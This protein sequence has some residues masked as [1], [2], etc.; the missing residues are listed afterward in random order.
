MILKLFWVVLQAKL[1][2]IVLKWKR[3]YVIYILSKLTL[4]S[5]FVQKLCLFN[6]L[7]MT[8]F[9]QKN[10]GQNFLQNSFI[11]EKIMDSAGSLYQKN[12]LEIGPGLGFLTSKILQKKPRKLITVEI[13]PRS[14][15]ILRKDF[16]HKDNFEI[17]Q[18]DILQQD[19][20][21]IWKKEPYLLIANIPYN[22]TGPILRKILSQT[23]NKPQKAILMVQKEVGEKI[24]SPKKKSLLYWSVALY[25]TSQKVCFVPRTDFSPV[26]KVDS[27][28]IEITPLPCPLLSPEKEKIFFDVLHAGFHQK[29]KK[30]NNS[31]GGFFGVP[32]QGLLEGIDG[33]LRAEKLSFDDW[34]KIMYNY[35][36][37]FPKS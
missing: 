24:V 7:S 1:P 35:E 12:V 9:A 28:V 25:A 5:Y 10:L 23:K 30:L 15:E 27:C 36:R 17:I 11:R 26:P 14:V 18:D 19:L 22:I 4:T 2:K 21:Q 31:I 29:R 3:Q 32:S 6:S 13:D 8:P 37:L 33:D 20:D 34:Q 16:Q